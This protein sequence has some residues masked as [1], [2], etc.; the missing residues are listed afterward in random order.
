MA[1]NKAR[2]AELR[3]KSVFPE[4]SA[5]AEFRFRSQVICLN[6]FDIAQFEGIA[7]L[8]DFG[9][10]RS[11]ISTIFHELT[12]WSDMVGTIWGRRHLRIVHSALG[13]VTSLKMA[14]METQFWKMIALHD[15][16]RRLMFPRYYR[17]QEGAG[18]LGTP[19]DSIIDFSGGIEFD[20]LGRQNADRPILFV[21][22]YGSG[23]FFIRQP[24]VVG[25]LL[26]TTAVWSEMKSGFEIAATLQNGAG[27]VENALI[28][29][30]LRSLLED[31]DLTIYT[32]PAR[33]V[34]YFASISDYRLVYELA[35]S[36]AYLCLNFREREFNKLRVP[37][38]MHV[39]GR[40]NDAWKRNMDP[41]FAFAAICVNAG[42]W[43]AGSTV[44]S[45]L[46]GG[47][48]RS[49]L[50][51]TA[52][53]REAAIVAMT[54]E[55]DLPPSSWTLQGSY[56][57]TAGLAS[58]KARLQGAD[59]SLTMSLAVAEGLPLPPIIDSNCEVGRLVFSTFDY[60]KWNPEEMFDVEY[61]L[62]GAVANMLSA[63]R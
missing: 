56:L 58:A 13:I 22:F 40:R 59:P 54:A 17:V 21:R 19:K 44:E 14:G 55:D 46:D 7:D 38:I 34:S 10:A 30:E 49:G 60:E 31:P 51:S 4:R 20:T 32:A 25:A 36:L 57:L 63:C 48:K 52:V 12:H 18:K 50:P 5:A 15:A 2:M 9:R 16:E 37:A 61:Q 11:V 45:W 24:F 6:E 35:A 47:L 28:D 1:I 43:S 26:E 62:D 42:R 39:W 23:S 8:A 3:G 33:M 29:A 27:V 41:A 53:I